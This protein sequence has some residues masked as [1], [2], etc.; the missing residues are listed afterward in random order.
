MDRTL[1]PVPLS[2]NFTDASH[3]EKSARIVSWNWEFGDGATS[4]IPNPSHTYTVPGSYAPRLTVTTNRGKTNACAPSTGITAVALPSVTEISISLPG[5]VSLVLVRVP[6]GSF[7]MGCPA[8][9]RG[10]IGNELPRHNV[11][12]A[13]DFYM[14]KYELTQAQWL[15]LMGSWPDWPPTADAGLGDNYPAYNLTWNDAQDFV[16]ALNAHI[17]AT[18]Q[19]SATMRLPSEA[20]WEYACRAGTT[21]RFFFGDSL[22]C[23][24][25]S[26]NCAA[27]VMPG[28]RI[29]YLWYAGN[30]SPNTAKAVGEKLPNGFGLYDMSGNVTEWVY[31]D[32]RYGYTGAP[33][34]GQAWTDSPRGPYRVMRG[35]TYHIDISG[36]RSGSRWTGEVTLRYN[37]V[38]FRVVR[39]S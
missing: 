35:G 5:G 37:N 19:G 33:T 17:T 21:T 22:E 1:G 20:E 2:V 24:D 15:A 12:F 36:C 13:S 9:E 7:M 23:A 26:E 10:V 6:A 16:A 14:G 39:G 38:G 28:D 11:T 8:D 32:W 29:D 31:D 25:T 3:I 18:A 34:D 27:G 30:N 4:D